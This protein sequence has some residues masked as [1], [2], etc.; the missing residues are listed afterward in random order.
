MTNSSR[1]LLISISLL[2]LGINGNQQ[3]QSFAVTYSD[4][5]S[6]VF[7]QS[8]SD[9]YTPQSYA[10]ESIAAAMAYRI[11]PSGDRDNRPFNLYG[12][13]FALNAAKTVQSIT[14]PANRNVVV[15]AMTP[16]ASMAIA[17]DNSR[18]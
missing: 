4:G 14:L 18:T 1:I 7:T 10:G 9:W 16:P 5:T 13:S 2:A 11:N 8:L 6:S 17:E 15:L 3:G 12:Y